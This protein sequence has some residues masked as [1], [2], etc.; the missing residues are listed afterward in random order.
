MS[1]WS[2]ASLDDEFRNPHAYYYGAVSAGQVVGISL[3]HIVF[4]ESHILKIGVDPSMRRRGIGRNLLAYVLARA[5]NDGAT[6]CWLEVRVSNIVAQTMYQR[7]GFEFVTQRNEYYPDNL[8]AALIY[9]KMLA[10]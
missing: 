5:E 6:E 8:E 1:P 7:A 2:R 10:E 9:R 4:E 3:L